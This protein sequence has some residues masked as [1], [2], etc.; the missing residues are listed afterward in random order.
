M[1]DRKLFFYALFASNDAHCVF[2]CE[3]GFSASALILI[4]SAEHLSA[5]LYLQFSASQYISSEVLGNTVPT[6]FCALS[7]A[8]KKEAQLVC[9]ESF[10]LR[11]PTWISGRQQYRSLLFE[12]F[13]TSQDKFVIIAPSLFV[14]T[15]MLLFPDFIQKYDS[16]AF[17]SDS[18]WRKS[19]RRQSPPLECRL[20]KS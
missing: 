20:L 10:A 2:D 13:I 19:P 16:Y 7:V 1:F 9:W 15:I 14:C 3:C 6:A 8:S 11:P 18:R 5:L 12:Q 17:E 4:W